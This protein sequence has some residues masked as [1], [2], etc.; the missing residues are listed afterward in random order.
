MQVALFLSIFFFISA[1]TFACNTTPRNGSQRFNK[2]VL[3]EVNHDEFRSYSILNIESHFQG[4]SISLSRPGKSCIKQKYE[5][6][7]RPEC[8]VKVTLKSPTKCEKKETY[9]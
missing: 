4:I 1:S 7:G 9:E 8:S 5:V 3:M 2:A 6:I